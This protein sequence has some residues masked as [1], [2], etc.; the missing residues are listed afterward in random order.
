GYTPGVLIHSGNESDGNTSLQIDLDPFSS[1]F[2]PMLDPG[3]SFTDPD[4]NITFRTLSADATG[5]WISVEMPVAPCTMRAPNVTLSPSGTVSATAG[6][7]KAFTMTVK[8]NDDTTCAAAVFASQMSVPGGW[9][10]TSAYSSI[11]L[12]PGA[13]TPV[14]L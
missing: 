3:Q 7:A 8:N 10:W 14:A 5:A 13:S 2:D 12:V 6:V 4:R 9:T 11:T 1:G